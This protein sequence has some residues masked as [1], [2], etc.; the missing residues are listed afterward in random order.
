MSQM[1]A[2]P[3]PPR[4][5]RFSTR[6]LLYI[7]LLVTALVYLP[8]LNGGFLFDDFPNIVD[9]PG[10]QP[11]H[12]DPQALARAA[13]SSPASDFKR[14]LASLSFAMNYLATGLD[15][16]WMKLTN[17]AIHLLNGA[18]LYWL[19][20][21][22]LQAAAGTPP[23]RAATPGQERLAL[24]IAGAWLVLPINLTAVLYVVQ[25]MES[26]ANVFVLLGLIAYCQG[27]RDM[28]AGG[29]GL[30][31]CALG[32]VGGT[33]CGLLAKETAILLPLYAALIEVCVFRFR[34]IE[35]RYDARI[36]LLLLA[37]F[38]L[39]F[40]AGFI[41]QLRMVLHP[42]VWVERDFTLAQR[43]LSEARIVV[44]YIVWTLLPTPGALSFFHDDF[45]ISR[46]LL[47][48]W[49]T[50]LGIAFIVALI[51]VALAQRRRRPLLSLGIALFLGA[52]TLTATI[53]PLELIFEHRNYFASFGLLLAVLPLCAAPRPR[54]LLGVLGAW[55]LA[56]TA[57]TAYGWGDQ[58]RV[59]EMLAARAPAS[60]RAQL[61]LG[62]SYLA[63]SRLAPDA[64]DTA[65]ARAAFERAAALPGGSSLPDSYLITMHARLGLPI[66]ERW[67]TGLLA[68]LRA[69]PLRGEDIGSLELLVACA[70]EARC[71]LPP[72]RVAEAFAA[73]LAWPG[74]SARLRAAYA[75]YRAIADG[76]PDRRA[77]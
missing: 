20:L 64:A 53:L 57:I 77:D 23:T 7:V 74:P 50:A 22:I 16:R 10:V 58:V 76:A 73:A 34:A 17:I 70:G 56:L 6:S 33:A 8:G 12:L 5:A 15:Y 21:L 19:S 31:R 49:T 65:R 29:R 18:L 66:E 4:A 40:A 61:T 51:A 60:P 39:P 37:V 26:L 13:W 9:N 28:L 1:E 62:E 48:P 69:K 68:R 3:S 32:I 2:E 30:L 44:S 24:A 63:L 55:W 72:D 35:R 43:L 75:R 52:H 27:R 38:V 47:D 42:Q 14:P 11:Q 25:R 46:G 67:W 36:G 45:R 41:W 54:L 71:A 59:T